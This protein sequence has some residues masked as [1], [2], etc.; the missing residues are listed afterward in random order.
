MST[1]RIRDLERELKR[2]PGNLALRLQLAA[3]LR[4]GLRT[5]EAVQLYRSVARAYA[6]QGRP[7]QAAAVCRAA[8]DIV[9]EDSEL[10]GMLHYLERQA[11]QTIQPPVGGFTHRPPTMPL[12]MGMPPPTLEVAAA[13]P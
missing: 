8:L 3:A 10:Y 13:P 2:E 9:P 4:E 7:G 5:R 12:P 6:E 1:K 11:S